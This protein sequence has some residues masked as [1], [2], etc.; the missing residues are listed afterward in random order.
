MTENEI[1]IEE[2][3][4]AYL[5][6]I[7]D[8]EGC[9]YIDKTGALIVVIGNSNESVITYIH[10]LYKGSIQKPKK[11][12]DRKQFYRWEASGLTVY[13]L[14]KD[15]YSYLI[16]KKLES[17]VAL[18]Y[19]KERPKILPSMRCLGRTDEDRLRTKIFRDYL[20]KIK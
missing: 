20:Q 16:I 7:F 18:E 14:L 6:G 2:T 19:Y 12:I 13:I 17:A 15:I 5:A 9:V 3:D 8:G 10:K 1:I 4:K 11:K